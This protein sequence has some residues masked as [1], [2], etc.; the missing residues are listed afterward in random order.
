MIKLDESI[1]REENVI[2]TVVFTL[3]DD[4]WRLK[5]KGEWLYPDSTYMEG[6][7]STALKHFKLINSRP[8]C[9]NDLEIR[10]TNVMTL[11]GGGVSG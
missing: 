7:L 4:E 5:A 9:I 8:P 2:F 3:D 11:L 6:L 1:S 10:F